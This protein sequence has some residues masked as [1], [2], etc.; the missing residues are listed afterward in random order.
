MVVP[1][2]VVRIYADLMEQFADDVTL[3]WGQA[4]AI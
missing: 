4:R 1:G 3:F 2:T